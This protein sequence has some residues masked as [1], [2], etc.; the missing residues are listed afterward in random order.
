MTAH[1][2]TWYVSQTPTGYIAEAY[3][4]VQDTHLHAAQ[5]VSQTA[6][7]EGA[8]RQPHR[9]KVVGVQRAAGA[10]LK[11]T[12]NPPPMG[13]AKGCPPL[14]APFMAGGACE[15]STGRMTRCTVLPSVTSA[16]QEEF[17]ERKQCELSRTTHVAKHAAGF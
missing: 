4:A 11:A 16:W 8:G 1:V 13:P 6:C 15:V 14:S 5:A 3:S 12:G 2:G 7:S 10:T 9:A 17:G